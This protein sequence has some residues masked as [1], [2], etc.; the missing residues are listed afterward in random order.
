MRGFI[1]APAHNTRWDKHQ[2]ILGNIAVSVGD[3]AASR[4]DWNTDAATHT[5]DAVSFQTG[6]INF[7][8]L[9]SVSGRPFLFDNYASERAVRQQVFDALQRADSRLEVVAYFGHGWRNGLGSCHITV[10]HLHRFSALLRSKLAPDAKIIFYG[11]STAA[12]G[13]F[14]QRL[15]SALDD[16]GVTIFGHN[17][18]GRYWMMN[19][20]VRYPNGDL[21][22]RH[23]DDGGPERTFWSRFWK[24]GRGA[25][26]PWTP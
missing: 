20:L 23:A 12:A 5:N 8:S 10:D 24:R 16:T 9:N 7:R 22:P 25:A 1:F 19:N 3:R 17:I 14:A 11:C 2:A 4:S 21:I 13:G 18:T 6:A 15:Q 26:A